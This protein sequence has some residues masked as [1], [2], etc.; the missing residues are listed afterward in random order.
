MSKLITSLVAVSVSLTGAFAWP[1]V[2]MLEDRSTSSN[3][4]LFAYGSDEDSEIGGFPIF[5]HS[6]ESIGTRAGTVENLD[7]HQLTE[8]K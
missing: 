3:F 1:G 8:G 7:G 2:S 4:S 6:G 5:Y